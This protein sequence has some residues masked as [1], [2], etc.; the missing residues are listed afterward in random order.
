[1]VKRRK[2]PVKKKTQTVELAPGLEGELVEGQSAVPDFSELYA[3]WEAEA[4]GFTLSMGRTSTNILEFIKN[5]G[6]KGRAKADG[7]SA[8]KVA[9]TQQY[10]DKAKSAGAE[11]HYSDEQIE[12]VKSL[13]S[14]LGANNSPTSKINPANIKF[15]GIADFDSKGRITEK[16]PVF[17]DFRTPMY[18]KYRRRH[19]GESVKVA[20]SDWYAIGEDGAGKA[21]P[22]VWQALFGNGDLQFKHPS[23]LMM[24]DMVLDAF[25]KGIKIR[26]TREKPFDLTIRNP[27]MRG[28]AAKWV[29]ENIPTFK[30][31]FDSKINNS[32]YHYSTGNVNT[33]KLQREILNT[34]LPLKD[35]ESKKIQSWLQTDLKVDLEEVYLKISVRQLNNMVEIAGFKNKKTEKKIEKQDFSDWRM[36]IKTVR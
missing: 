10:L 29:Y 16:V 12:A 31:W 24:C 18:A 15:N 3:S 11:D 2:K 14:Y 4:K 28:E 22:P 32:A 26:N 27:K 23:L 36:I 13:K 9:P 5:M 19:K 20:N 17:G 8:S 21:K 30:N 35:D 1:M 25:E 33:K 34:K 6:V 7:G